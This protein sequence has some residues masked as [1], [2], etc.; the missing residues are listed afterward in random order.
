[1]LFNGVITA[2]ISWEKGSFHWWQIGRYI[3]IAEDARVTDNN[4]SGS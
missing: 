2:V 1:M 4:R 3:L